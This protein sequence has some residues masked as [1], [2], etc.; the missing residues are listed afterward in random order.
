MTIDH[1]QIDPLQTRGAWRA[2]CS[3]GWMGDEP[4]PNYMQAFKE[5]RQVA[6]T[7]STNACR[8]CAAPLPWGEMFCGKPCRTLARGGT[9]TP[10]GK[11]VEVDPDQGALFEV[12]AEDG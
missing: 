1:A 10:K 6:M 12:V 11:P 9:L 8:Y 3:C 5:H 7:P 4:T 2:R